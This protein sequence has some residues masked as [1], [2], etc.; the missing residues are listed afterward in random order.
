MGCAKSKEMPV[1]GRR[2]TSGA[3][4][5]SV[6]HLRT[7]DL[8]LFGATVARDAIIGS[9]TQ[10]QWTHIGVV[11]HVPEFYN[12]RGP[13]LL[14]CADTFTDE[15]PDLA[16][17]YNVRTSGVRLVDLHSRIQ[18]SDAQVIACRQLYMGT[19]ATC[20]LGDAHALEFITLAAGREH[21]TVG[22]DLN[23]FKR[24]RLAPIS[25]S[26]LAA[27]ALLHLG[28][29]HIAP[30]RGVLSLAQR[31]DTTRDCAYEVPRELQR[32]TS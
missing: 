22:A 21:G 26:E 8:V 24:T 9:R 5:V 27:L 2:L 23:T 28:I 25:A 32:Q 11:M 13:M 14:E 6:D 12:A 18:L 16:W 10:T 29:S 15:L 17:K 1:E 4:S 19:S 20:Q 31:F 3:D 30:T 7:G